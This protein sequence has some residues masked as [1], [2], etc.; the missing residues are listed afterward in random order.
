MY[1]EKLIHVSL[2]LWNSKSILCLLLHLCVL[3]QLQGAPTRIQQNNPGREL[4]NSMSYMNQSGMDVDNGYQS[5]NGLAPMQEK[6]FSILRP[7]KTEVG[8][9]REFIL[10]NF[11]PN[12]HRDVK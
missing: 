8:L 9:S 12:Q 5:T 4:V 1:D 3:C 2:L 11:P 7:V 6:V 10:K